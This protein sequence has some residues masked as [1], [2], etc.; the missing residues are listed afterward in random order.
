[1]KKVTIDTNII[2]LQDIEDICRKKGYKISTISVTNREVKNTKYEKDLKNVNKLNETM[3]WGES[4]WG[5]SVWGDNES[6]VVF[7]EILSIISNN[8][9]PKKRDNLSEGHKRMLRDAMIFEG[10]VRENR[11]IFI[12]NDER[13]FVKNGHRKILENKFCTKILTKQEFMAIYKP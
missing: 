6:K 5:E 11:D 9:F 12:S 2:P 13:A 1:M 8:T 3:I 7:E 10:H 4:P